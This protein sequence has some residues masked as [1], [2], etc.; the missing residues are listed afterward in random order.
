MNTESTGGIPNY[1][2]PPAVETDPNDWM[3]L[4]R[5][6][7]TY[8]G[9]TKT[10]IFGL[11]KQKKIRSVRIKNSTGK[12]G[13]LLIYRPSLLALIAEAESAESETEQREG[14]K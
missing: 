10:Y 3:R 2:T 14:A 7:S 9:L 5:P 6:G 12:T 8:F 1:N 11:V 4:P 13:V